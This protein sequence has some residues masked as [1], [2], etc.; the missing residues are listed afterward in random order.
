MARAEIR[1]QPV[2]I[3]NIKTYI[4]RIPHKWIIKDSFLDHN[5]NLSY[6]ITYGSKYAQS[7]LIDANVGIEELARDLNQME[8]KLE[9]ILL[10]H[11]HLD[12]NF[13]LPEIM[14]KYKDVHIG[15]HSQGWKNTFPEIPAEKFIELSENREIRVGKNV[16]AALPAPGHTIDALCFWDKKNRLFFAGD[17]ILGG[18]IGCCDYLSGGNKNDFYSTLV[19]LLQL[20]PDETS[21]F[22]G[23][24]LNHYSVSPPYL[25]SQEKD[26][27]PYLQYA[28]A[29]QRSKFNKAL[30]GLSGEFDPVHRELP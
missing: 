27:N 26:R 12:H 8:S 13:R 21:I 6:L 28:A 11:T 23:H 7:I 22:P 19:N 10:T 5:P 17:L 30:R 24:R 20:L 3:M 14:A 25:W 15:I 18:E 29:G 4:S 1:Q 2:C 9:W 16:L